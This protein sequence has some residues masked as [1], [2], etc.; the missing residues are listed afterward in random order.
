[1]I[2]QLKCAFYCCQPMFASLRVR[3]DNGFDQNKQLTE[4][5]LRFHNFP[6]EVRFSLP[7]EERGAAAGEERC[8][9]PIQEL[10]QLV[11]EMWARWPRRLP[12]KRARAEC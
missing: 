7:A 12:G 10:V 4:I 6:I 3:G 9:R 2:N 5:P 1:M 8:R 11:P